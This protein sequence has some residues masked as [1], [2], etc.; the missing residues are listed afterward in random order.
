MMKGT[1]GDTLRLAVYKRKADGTGI[2]SVDY[3]TAIATGNWQRIALTITTTADTAYLMLIGG[4]STPNAVVYVDGLQIEQK[5]YPTSWQDPAVARAGE[6]PI[7]DLRPVIGVAPPYF[8]AMGVWIPAYTRP[9]GSYAGLMQIGTTTAN[10]V[11]IQTIWLAGSGIK[12]AVG[13]DTT[14]GNTEVSYTSAVS[15]GTPIAWAAWRANDLLACAMK[16]GS[17]DVLSAYRRGI[18]FASSIPAY[19]RIGHLHWSPTHC[20]GRMS[21]V[22]LLPR[23]PISDREVRS[24]LEALVAGRPIF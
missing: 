20:G 15:P 4:A 19:F 5:S 23:A 10:F 9:Y 21:R 8:T 17:A 1:A 22:A 14:P 6:F 24:W 16:V 18:V 12:M 3:T 11:R 13:T 7:A 2:G